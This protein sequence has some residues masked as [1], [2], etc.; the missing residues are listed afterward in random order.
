MCDWGGGP[1]EM[2]NYL[3]PPSASVS[4][5]PARPRRDRE[6]VRADK[7]HGLWSAVWEAS[8]VMSYDE[9]REHVEGSLREVQSDEP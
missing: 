2:A 4:A 6:Q 1:N 3:P 9:I 8:Q 7:R 5:G